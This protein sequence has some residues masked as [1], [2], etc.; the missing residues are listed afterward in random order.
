M[1]DGLEEGGKRGSDCSTRGGHEMQDKGVRSK[2]LRAETK[3][4]QVRQA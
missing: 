1:R 4:S 2:D 3:V